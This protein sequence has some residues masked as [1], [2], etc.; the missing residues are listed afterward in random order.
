[1][2]TTNTADPM[3]VTGPVGVPDP[4]PD[5]DPE[6]SSRSDKKSGF[7]RRAECAGG[8][9]E[10]KRARKVGGERVVKEAEGKNC[11]FELNTKGDR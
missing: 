8:F 5:P 1:M 4:D 7:R 10:R 9:M 2:R 3:P 11:K 6:R